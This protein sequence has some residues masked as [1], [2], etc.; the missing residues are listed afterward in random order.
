MVIRMKL[1]EKIDFK[2]LGVR[3]IKAHLTLK[4]VNLITETLNLI[5]PEM[6]QIYGSKGIFYICIKED[7]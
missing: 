3:V 4:D 6:F 1:I 5:S 2:E 7:R